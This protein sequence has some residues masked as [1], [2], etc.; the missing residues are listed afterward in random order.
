MLEYILPFLSHILGSFFIFLTGNVYVSYLLKVFITLLLLL[1]FMRRYGLRFKFCLSSLFVGLIIF[2]VW[3]FLPIS[4]SRFQFVPPT[5]FFLFVKFVGAVFVA[6]FVEEL[7]TR[8]FLIRVFVRREWKRVK[9][10]T[11]TWP[12]FI[13][14][15]LFFGF[16]HNMW[17][18]GLVVGIV[19]NLWLY[20][21]KSV[22][23]CIIAH[24]FANFLLF[25][26]VI[27]TSAF[28]LW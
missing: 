20:K 11:F 19:L 22:E 6:P 26:Y 27:N 16:S 5:S 17:V 14:T 24:A 25:F 15:V 13:V 23:Q 21:T 18:A 28:S 8:G 10:G 2:L 12:S 7:F 1:F 9:V 4:F 3:I